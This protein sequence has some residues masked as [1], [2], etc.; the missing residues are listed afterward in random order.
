MIVPRP[1][2]GPSSK[3]NSI[4]NEAQVETQPAHLDM[5]LVAPRSSRRHCSRSLTPP[6][7]PKSSVAPSQIRRHGYSTKEPGS[8]QLCAALDCVARPSNILCAGN[9]PSSAQIIS[10]PMPC[11][12]RNWDCLDDRTRRRLRSAWHEGKRKLDGNGLGAHGTQAL[13]SPTAD[14][15]EF[16]N[17]ALWRRA[18]RT[19]RA[20]RRS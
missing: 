14:I 3:M 17:T 15:A 16:F 2:R 5:D 1:K 19:H 4:R 10:K 6:T 12:A 9:A 8:R 7:F 18:K 11:A 20:D 13:Q